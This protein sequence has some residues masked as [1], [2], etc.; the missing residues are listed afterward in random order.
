MA[1]A[2][3]W[4]G[5]AVVAALALAVPFGL[6]QSRALDLLAL[7]EDVPRSLGVHVARLRILVL[8][9]VVLLCGGAYAVAGGI[10][11]LGLLA[12]H[13][14]RQIVGVRHAV[15]LPASMA[16]GA[17]LLMTADTLGRVVT[18]PADTPA[19][20]LVAVLGGP[21][22]LGLLLWTAWRGRQAIRLP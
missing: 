1:S 13:V 3:A 19:G 17:C 2:D 20:I 14:A 15:L 10:P 5:V 6:A 12:P 7:G 16:V 11:F 9:V 8:G 21:W 4:S 22:F 18:S